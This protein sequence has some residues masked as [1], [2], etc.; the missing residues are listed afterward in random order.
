MDVKRGLGCAL[1]VLFALAL[2]CGTQAS[3]AKKGDGGKAE[4]FKKRTFKLKKGGK[5]KV[6]LTFPAG[7]TFDVKVRSTGKP[8]VNLFIYDADKKEVAKDDS[9]GPDCDIEFTPKEAGKYTLEVVNQGPKSTTSTLTVTLKKKK[10][11]APKE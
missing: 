5:G 1:A 6:T 11:P 8:D 3:A 2:L 4:K 7:K 10:K 9:P